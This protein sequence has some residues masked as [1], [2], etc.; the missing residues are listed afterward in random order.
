MKLSVVIVTYNRCA[1]LLRTLERLGA[2]P[3]L[4][5]DDMEILIVDNGSTDGTA[6]AV[7]AAWPAIQVLRR[8][9]NEGV[10]ARNHAFDLARGCYVLLIDDDS[11]P[12]GDA[13]E[14]SMNYLDFRA[15]SAAVVGRVVL[16]DGSLEAKRVAYRDDQLC[17]LPAE[18]GA[19]PRGR[20]A[21]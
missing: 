7:A 16:P 2:N 12:V 18:I 21:P 17:R 6:A 15:G 14:R 10:S 3:R 11:Y 19:G 9:G 13:V 1:T 8:P 4:P 20:Y 5:H